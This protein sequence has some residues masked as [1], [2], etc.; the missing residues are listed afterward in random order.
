M[1]ILSGLKAAKMLGIPNCK[2]LLKKLKKQSK[3]KLT[4]V[5]NTFS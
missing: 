1:E 3:N 2:K 4:L 5:T